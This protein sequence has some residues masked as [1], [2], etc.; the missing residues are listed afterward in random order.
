VRDL[1]AFLGDSK[2]FDDQSLMVVQKSI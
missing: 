1:D 2:L